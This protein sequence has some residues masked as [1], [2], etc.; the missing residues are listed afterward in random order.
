MLPH[1]ADLKT[2]FYILATA[3]LFFYQ[4]TAG[5]QWVIYILYLFLSIAISVIIHNHVHNPIWKSRRLNQVTDHVLTIF[6]G[7]P[8]FVWIPTHV[9][10][11]HKYVNK[12]PDD[13]KTYRVSEK[14][15]FL[16]LISYPSISGYY[17][18][19]AI[20]KFLKNV[21][22]KNRKKFFSYSAQGITLVLWIGTAL[23]LDWQKALIFVVAPQQVSLFS[24]LIFNYLQHVHADKESD[25]NH[26]RNIMGSLNFFHFNNGLH[27][28]YHEYPGLHWSKLRPKHD[29]IDHLIDERL[30]ELNMI[31]FI[32]RVYLIGLFRLYERR[33]FVESV[34]KIVDHCRNFQEREA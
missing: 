10:N 21:Y 33:T 3:G 8:V 15:N 14:N 13:T 12:E 31:L 7:I 19:I 29:E 22:R 20:V 30:K 34:L 1:R 25:Y 28:I 9:K 23:I 24:V 2:I 16:T 5:F 26:S 17:Q 27:T 4:W 11:H 32:L 18:N 6:Y